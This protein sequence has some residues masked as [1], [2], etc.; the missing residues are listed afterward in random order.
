MTSK[1]ELCSFR[2]SESGQNLILLYG[3]GYSDSEMRS[4]TG[5]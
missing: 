4:I 5:C 2:E 1:L 3:D